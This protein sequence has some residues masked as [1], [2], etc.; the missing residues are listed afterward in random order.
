MVSALDSGASGPGSSPGRGHC[1]VLLGKT[2]YSHSAS[3]HPGVKMG[4]SEFNAGGNPV[5]DQHPIQGGVEILSVASCYGNRDKLRP[6]GPFGSNADF[7]LARIESLCLFNFGLRSR[8]KNISKI[9]QSNLLE[10]F[11]RTLKFFAISHG[12][13]PCCSLTRLPIMCSL[14]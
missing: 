11:L 7:F 13:F 6:D 1:V 10:H 4:T 12:S 3:L 5:M 14:T 2:L 8:I 9:K